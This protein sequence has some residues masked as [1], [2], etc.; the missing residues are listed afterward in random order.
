MHI[1]NILKLTGLMIV[2]TLGSAQNAQAQTDLWGGEVNA[3]VAVVSDYR[4][5]GVSKTDND[6]AVQGNL[7][8][9]SDS[10]LYTGLWASNVS[11][12]K[13]ADLET[14]LYLGINKEING[15]IY[16]AG[17]T[18]Y[19]Y[20]G[21]TNANYIETYGSVGVDFGLLTSSVGMA[22][23]FSSDN[24]GNQ[25]NIYFYNNT[26][27]KIPNTPFSIEAHLGYEDGA[28]GNKKWD[29][30]LGASVSFDQFEVGISYVDTNIIG[31]RSDSGVIFKVGA[32]F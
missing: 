13:G 23:I 27:A 9:V 3:N 31:K 21:G 30:K 18:A 5:R 15:F 26:R 6:F 22:Y 11:D 8:W 12:F 4:F 1:R 25:D 10:G 7:D 28:F 2:A 14:N 17:F 32:Y 29:W 24:I 20:P 16:D 19:V